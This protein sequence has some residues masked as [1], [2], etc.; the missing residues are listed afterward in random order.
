MGWAPGQE[1][2]CAAEDPRL[3]VCT[4]AA[5]AIYHCN[6]IQADRQSRGAA[7]THSSLSDSQSDSAP[8]GASCR[9]GAASAAKSNTLADQAGPSPMDAKQPQP[10]PWAAW[11]GKI[12]GR[13]LYVGS[14]S[15]APAGVGPDC[16][17]EADTRSGTHAQLADASD[18]HTAAAA[19]GNHDRE[20]HEAGTQHLTTGA[21]AAAGGVDSTFGGPGT[22]A[23]AEVAAQQPDAVP[24]QAPQAAPVG[25]NGANLDCSPS[26]VAEA[27]LPDYSAGESTPVGSRP[28][29]FDSSSVRT[30]ESD[31][32]QLFR[33]IT[34]SALSTQVTGN[35]S[36]EVHPRV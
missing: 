9:A 26:Q 5:S 17:K 11:W 4:S 18:T 10:P 27:V 24:G 6:L 23:T 13:P 25:N 35:P 14:A 1:N 28:L 2:P 3:R 16:S 12:R 29:V 8:D 7:S 20:R 15:E 36:L 33:S 31:S 30:Q 22:T 21:A 19:A 34:E 32:K